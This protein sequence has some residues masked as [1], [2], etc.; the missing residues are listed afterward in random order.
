MPQA[1][2][3]TPVSTAST[4]QPMTGIFSQHAELWFATQ[5]GLLADVD[6]LT[7]AWLHRRREGLEAMR[8]ALEQMMQ[9][10]EPTE[11]LLIQQE[12][13][14]GAFRRATDDIAALTN[15]VS[16]L[17]GKATSDLDGLTKTAFDDLGGM[18]KQATAT[19]TNGAASAARQVYAVA[20]D[21][22]MAA[23]N[24]PRPAS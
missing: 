4:D 7:H 8:Q 13:L 6:A 24:K 9:C 14:A 16:T 1:K 23:G 22:R 17:A 18:A 2:H 10:Q 11:M 20:E 19:L 5:A 15:T 3:G 21:M 12:W